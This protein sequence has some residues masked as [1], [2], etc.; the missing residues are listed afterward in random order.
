MTF[1]TV[2]SPFL[3]RSAFLSSSSKFLDFELTFFLTRFYPTDARLNSGVVG[4]DGP[5]NAQ[6]RYVLIRCKGSHDSTLTFLLCSCSSK[7][8]DLWSRL[9]KKYASQPNV[10]FGLMNE[11]RSFF[12]LR[13]LSSFEISTDASPFPLVLAT[14][15]LANFGSFVTSL[16]A[17]VT[18]IRAAGATS[19]SILLPGNDWTH[20]ASMIS[21]SGPQLIT[22]KDTTSDSSRL[23]I[24]IHQVRSESFSPIRKTERYETLSNSS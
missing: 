7:F 3:S 5:S 13:V 2:D 20:A 11:P 12:P 15:D 10:I 18:A 24:D 22:I 1:I 17:A 19:Q 16:Q 14:D 4:V 23:L 8:A 21:T 6:V 9:A